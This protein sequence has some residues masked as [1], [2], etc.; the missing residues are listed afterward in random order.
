M[1]ADFLSSQQK[2]NSFT[3]DA[4]HPSLSIPPPPFSKKLALSILHV[5]GANQVLLDLTMCEVFR[6]SNKCG[7]SN[8]ATKY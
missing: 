2:I 8:K 6:S 5:F 7:L 4:F 3:L 1:N